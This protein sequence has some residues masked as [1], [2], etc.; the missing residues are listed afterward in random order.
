MGTG[1]VRRRSETG[2]VTAGLA[3]SN[4]SLLRV[5]CALFAWIPE[6]IT[7]SYGSWDY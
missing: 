7:G 5:T 4:A 6:I 1:Q 3:E 2:K